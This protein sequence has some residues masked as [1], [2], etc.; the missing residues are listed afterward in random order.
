MKRRSLLTRGLGALAATTEVPAWLQGQSPAATPE[1]TP[2]E[3][4]DPTP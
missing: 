3:T 1:P 2:D 4:T